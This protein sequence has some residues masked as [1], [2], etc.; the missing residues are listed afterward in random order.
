[1]PKTTGDPEMAGPDGA[2]RAPA[3]TRA[4]QVLRH[5]AQRAQPIGVNQLAAEIGLVPST[6]LHILRALAREGLVAVDPATKRYRLG[7]GVISLARAFLDRRTIAFTVQ[8]LIDRIARERGVTA[9]MIE[10]GDPDNLIVTA[11]AEGADMFSVKVT[12]GTAFPAFSSATG[13]CVAAHA[14]LAEARLRERFGAL[15]WQN[16]PEF[17][18]WRE[19]VR[20]VPRLGYAIDRGNYIRGLT[21]ISAPVHV[22]GNSLERCIAAVALKDQLSPSRQEALVAALLSAAGE[23]RHVAF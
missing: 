19:D 16:P 10:R 15:R 20:A 9:A 11:V 8:P 18:A 23:L 6:C 21:V 12:V 22:T 14:G 17:E 3:V 1:M 2:G 4:V 5:L 13:R 7:I